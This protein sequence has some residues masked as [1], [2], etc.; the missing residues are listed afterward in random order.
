MNQVRLGTFFFLVEEFF[1]HSHSQPPEEASHIEPGSHQARHRKKIEKKRETGFMRVG[2]GKRREL[3][4][5]FRVT[6][7]KKD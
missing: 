5:G 4:S 1:I 3:D 6:G 7:Y 2:D